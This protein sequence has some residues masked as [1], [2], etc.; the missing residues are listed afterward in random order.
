MAAAPGDRFAFVRESS[1]RGRLNREA[2][3]EEAAISISNR[4]L[5]ESLTVYLYRGKRLLAVRPLLGPG[6]KAPFLCDQTVMIGTS[7]RCREGE[8]VELTRLM[9]PLAEINLSGIRKGRIIMTG[10]GHGPSSQP[11][12]FYLEKK[13]RW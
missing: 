3:V 8:T 4:T 9:V 13:E 12:R 10:G 7:L 6:E 1:G 5:Q 11:L 2:A